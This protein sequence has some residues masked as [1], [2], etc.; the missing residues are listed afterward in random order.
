MM[1]SVITKG[2]KIK[3]CGTCGQARG[4]YEL[5]LIEGVEKSNMIEYTQWVVES[6]K[7]INI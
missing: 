4:V 2:G 3:A 7:V 6:D 5:T 1:K